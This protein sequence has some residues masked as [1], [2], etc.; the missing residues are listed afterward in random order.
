MSQIQKSQRPHMSEIVTEVMQQHKPELANKQNDP[1]S[2]I[3]GATLV[4]DD[5]EGSEG[6][7]ADEAEL[8]NSLAN[9]KLNAERRQARHKYEAAI[10]KKTRELFA[11]EERLYSVRYD[12][13]RSEADIMLDVKNFI[14]EIVRLETTIKVL[15]EKALS[16]FE[17]SLNLRELGLSSFDDPTWTPAT[18]TT[19]ETSI[20]NYKEMDDQE[21]EDLESQKFMRTRSTNTL[22]EKPPVEKWQSILKM[23]REWKQQSTIAEGQSVVAR[24]DSNPSLINPEEDIAALRVAIFNLKNRKNLSKSDKALLKKMTEKLK[25]LTQNKIII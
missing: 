15:R 14:K 4:V 24:G 17:A 1:L 18:V 11:I 13:L 2:I 19:L 12:P 6:S 20:S 9:A 3:K 25:E 22:K 7:E 16:T 10:L 21:L 23:F 5:D 8:K